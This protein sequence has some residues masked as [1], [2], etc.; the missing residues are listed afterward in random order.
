MYN[1]TILP[2]DFRGSL[3]FNNAMRQIN[4]FQQTF[5]HYKKTILIKRLN[6]YSN[7]P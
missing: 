4:L 3:L 7:K 2:M 6:K 1:K 5:D